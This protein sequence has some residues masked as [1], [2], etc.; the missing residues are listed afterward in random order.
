MARGLAAP[1]HQSHRLAKS[2]D[3]VGHA[4]KPPGAN[5]RILPLQKSAI[6]RVGIGTPVPTVDGRMVGG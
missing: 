5:Q 6:G 2:Q 3:P 1:A 4:D